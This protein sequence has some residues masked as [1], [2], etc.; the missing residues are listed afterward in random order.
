[1]PLLLLVG[2]AA[3]GTFTTSPLLV[4]VVDFFLPIVADASGAAVSSKEHGS[5]M[6]EGK[7]EWWS[8][9]Q[10]ASIVGWGAQCDAAVEARQTTEEK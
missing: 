8:S 4:G 2:L 5:L 1:M 10:N 9:G 3:T 7:D 6:L